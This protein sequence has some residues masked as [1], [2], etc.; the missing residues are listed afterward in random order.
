[1]NGAACAREGRQKKALAPSTPAA[2]HGKSRS[3]RRPGSAAITAGARL[4]IRAAFS[5][6]RLM[7]PPHPQMTSSG[8]SPS[9]RTTNSGSSARDFHCG[10]DRVRR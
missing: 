8:G 7:M 4:T 9:T 2:Q 6:I 10:P 5:L 1:M 3:V